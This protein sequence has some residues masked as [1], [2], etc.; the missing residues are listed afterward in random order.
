MN[1]S[2]L[3]TP[4]SISRS[5]P[6][7][8]AK[9]KKPSKGDPPSGVQATL[10]DYQLEGYHWMQSLASCRLNGILADD[11]GLGKT[12][13]T[14]AHILTEKDS[15]RSGGR[16]CLVVAP[17]SVVPNWQT[18]ATKFT[19]SLRILVLQGAKRKKNFPNIPY[20]DLVL[21]SFALL[22]RD[23]ENPPADPLPHCGARRGAEHQEPLRQG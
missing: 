2:S 1:P 15:G 14:L 20:A 16:P 21:T 11:M 13:Q 19:P 23:I 6:S 5:F 9:L 8:W 7:V 12:L 4:R 22:Q 18:E 17:T 3:S 10:R